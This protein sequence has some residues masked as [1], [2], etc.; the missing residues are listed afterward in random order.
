MTLIRHNIEILQ[1]KIRYIRNRISRI[2]YL[3]TILTLQKK[4]HRIFQKYDQISHRSAI[5]QQII[6][7]E[8]KIRLRAESLNKLEYE[9]K[10]LE[11][12][13]LPDSAGNIS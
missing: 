9:L 2:K 4:N 7:I 10:I 5:D 6:A 12:T 13:C 8:Q 3:H 1:L 11:I